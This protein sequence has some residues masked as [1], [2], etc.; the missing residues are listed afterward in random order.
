MGSQEEE[1]RTLK[2]RNEDAEVYA[3]KVVLSE[4]GP[5]YSSQFKNNYFAE[6]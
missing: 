1:T 5:G 6:M 2:E 4:G 3:N